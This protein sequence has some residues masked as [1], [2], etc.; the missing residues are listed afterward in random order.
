MKT[1]SSMVLHSVFLLLTIID[2]AQADEI[3]ADAGTSAIVFI[4]GVAL[5]IGEVKRWPYR[6]SSKVDKQ[7]GKDRCAKGKLES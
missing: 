3:N 1:V 6:R 2:S 5:L 4:V 7:R